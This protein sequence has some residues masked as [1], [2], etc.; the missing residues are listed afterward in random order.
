MMEYVSKEQQAKEKGDNQGA[1]KPLDTN[2]KH[3]VAG[4][5]G[6][7]RWPKTNTNNKSF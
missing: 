1:P 3:C 5:D 4:K 6:Q 7:K 2:P